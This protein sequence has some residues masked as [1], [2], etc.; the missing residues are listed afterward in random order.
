MEGGV[1]LESSE[2]DEYTAL[3]EI[4]RSRSGVVY[5]AISP[6]LG[7]EVVIKVFHGSVTDDDEIRESFLN[8]CHAVADLAGHPNIVPLLDAGFIGD[9]WPFV[10][11]EHCKGGSFADR[12]AAHGPRPMEEI[13]RVGVDVADAL[14]TAHS[15]GVVH[16]DI[17][18]RH[19]LLTGEGVVALGGFG[20]IARR[21]LTP[22]N[23]SSP[24]GTPTI[25]FAAPEA[26][27]GESRPANGEV[28]RQALSGGAP[29][30]VYALGATMYTLITGRAPVVR[31]RG[32][33]DL[34]FL[35]RSVS[36]PAPELPDSVP[37]PLAN[38][39]MAC[40]SKRPESRPGSALEVKQDLERAAAGAGLKAP[41]RLN[42]EPVPPSSSSPFTAPE[43]LTGPKGI[44]LPVTQTG[45]DAAPAEQPRAR[46]K[47]RAAAVVSA[48]AVLLAGIVTTVGGLTLAGVVDP[49]GTGDEE[50]SAP[51]SPTTSAASAAT[52]QTVP[53]TGP[54]TV[55]RCGAP[56]QL[57][58]RRLQPCRVIDGAS[59]LVYASP[60]SATNQVGSL[61]GPEEYF[62][63]QER[64]AKY[65]IGDRETAWWAFVRASNGQW[66]WIPTLYLSE[67]PGDGAPY[68][69]LL[70]CDVAGNPCR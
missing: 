29:A 43:L 23:G 41:P 1:P 40:L 36:D 38:V 55:S 10:V 67:A 54:A 26:L 22:P 63:G 44:P 47:R 20:V 60:D 21:G 70:S 64:G 25:G 28:P 31:R 39:V 50:T 30:D 8:R 35:L 24:P 5:R 27:A 18:P 34:Q 2:L 58:G 6:R 61:T 4:G 66:G 51:Q 15:K 9:G 14:A 56:V 68:P 32:E 46:K 69:G 11:T 52:A 62:A 3:H 57:A 17:T 19:V 65:Q 49:A 37:W 45:T 42:A 59:V 7:R 53:G 12:L 16:R 13:L 33:S 48:T